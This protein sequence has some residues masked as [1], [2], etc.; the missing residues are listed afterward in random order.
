MSPGI[1]I[2]IDQEQ[3]RRL[4]AE[5]CIKPDRESALKAM[6]E[7]YGNSTPTDDLQRVIAYT[8]KAN[9]LA[10]LTFMLG[11]MVGS[12]SVVAEIGN[13][14]P[15]IIKKS[16]MV[17]AQHSEEI[18]ELMNGMDEGEAPTATATAPKKKPDQTEEERMYG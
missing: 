15:N 18:K 14:I 4:M 16:M 6:I 7:G 12:H 2:G 9:E 10:F 5:L 8:T 3:V 1:G 13:E 11:L 17:G